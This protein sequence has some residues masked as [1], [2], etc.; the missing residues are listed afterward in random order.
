MSN[1]VRLTFGRYDYASYIAFMAY[2]A[3]SLVVPASLLQISNS[4]GFPL[5][6]G[7]LGHGGFIEIGRTFTMTVLLLLSSFI[8]GRFGLRKT[9]GAASLVMCLGCLI[10]TL[11]TSYWMLF[12]AVLIS[13]CGEGY[14]EAA[15]T[16]FVQKLHKQNTGQYMN[17]AHSFWSIG[18]TT[19][20]IGAG[21]MLACGLSWRLVITIAV[22]LSA[23]SAS[24]LLIPEK[25]GREYPE[26]REPFAFRTVCV[27]IKAIF[28]TPRFWLFLIMI[29]IAGGS[30]YCLTFWLA[31]FM[32][33]SM[34]TGSLLGGLATATFALGMVT[35]RMGWGILVPDKKLG[36]SLLLA[37]AA[38]FCLSCTIPF[39]NAD[40][41]IG[42]PCTLALLFAIIY[43]IGITIAPLWPTIQTYAVGRLP[44]GLDETLIFI[45]LSSSG[46]PGCG[47]FSSLM[48]FV[49]DCCGGLDKAILMVPSCELLLALLLFAE[50]KCAPSK[51]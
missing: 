39:I 3:S 33:L 31:S 24:L 17:F 45:L 28:K 50:S 44:K 20:T 18:V 29:F 5:A 9:L 21:A 26:S 40:L 49:G 10:I 42:R 23:A 43:L 22:L 7:G 38:G 36:I 25:T 14:I 48:G 19:T 11:S 8:A 6:D 41:P 2:A 13:G 12:A 51:L 32:Q 47:F 4:L 34:K 1:R 30:E 27:H 35:G 37:A 15:A 16:P 46:V